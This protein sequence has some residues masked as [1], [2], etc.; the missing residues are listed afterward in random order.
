MEVL[1]DT[2]ILLRLTIPK[3]PAHAVVRTAVRELKARGDSL[4]T[5]FQNVAEFWNVCT[6]PPSTRG[7]YGLTIQQT[8][9]KLLLIDR[10]MG[11]LHD[12]ADTVQEWR[13]LVV[14]HSVRGV[15]VHDARIVAA[16]SSYGITHLLTLNTDDFRR[17]QGITVLA[18]HDISPL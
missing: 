17:F 9:R 2:G 6:R 11:I 12:T 10:L 13:R 7:G 4:Y 8:N 18:P 14:N 3:D 15:Q 1:I 16:M 5:L